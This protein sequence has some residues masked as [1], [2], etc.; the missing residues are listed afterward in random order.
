M[1]SIRANSIQGE[2]SVKLIHALSSAILLACLGITSES[3]LAKATE[4]A[5]DSTS[6][7]QTNTVQVAG[8][9]DSLQ[10]VVN[11]IRQVNQVVDSVNSIVEQEN[12]RRELEAAQRAASEQERLEAEHRQQYFESLSPEQRQAYI[13]EQ[14]SRQNQNDQVAN[15]FLLMMFSSMMGGPSNASASDGSSNDICYVYNSDGTVAYTTT[16]D[17][18]SNFSGVECQSR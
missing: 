2:I 13:Q 15:L 12:N 8:F 4:Q 14:K 9:F 5:P 6:S 7:S 17:Q 1:S 3:A 18:I 11:T 16:R 10:D